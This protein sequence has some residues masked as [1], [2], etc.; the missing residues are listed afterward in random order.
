[1]TKPTTTKPTTVGRREFLASAALVGV[2]LAVSP[3]AGAQTSS[4]HADQSRQ[5]KPG[6]TRMKNRNLGQLQVSELGAGA[7]SIS[8]NYGP[9]ADR[10]QGIATL[11]AA[12]ENGVTFFDTAEVY[13]PYTNEDLVGEALA[14]FR[15]QVVIASKFGFDLE[16]GGL[17]SRPEHI[18]KVVEGSLKRLRTDRIDLYYQH[19]VDPA[20]P[21]EEVAG[22]I[23]ELIAQG[24]V[25]HFGLSEAS[26]ANIRRAHA[27]QPVTAVQSEYAFWFRG[28]EGNGVLKACE[29][30]GIGFVPWSPIGQG[31]LTGKLDASIQFDPKNDFRANFPRLTKENR[32]K[33]LPVV[34]LLE[35]VAKHNNTTPSALALAWLLAQKPFIVPIPGTRRQ[36]H[37]LENL[38]A[39][40]ISL[41]S[42]DL[43]ELESEYA[44]L[45]VHG[46]RM[47]EANMRAIDG[48]PVSTI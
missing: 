42:A 40:D 41:S 5:A 23:K 35:R 12:H 15:D 28:P 39:I 7:M 6:N 43:Q 34:Q 46:L 30:L 20:V 44:L 31:Y 24:K 27:V 29:E 47:D 3:F 4:S 2:G 18:R 13:G 10:K 37:L 11:R 45:T 33:N 36:D 26:A 1:M 14:P 25:L 22:T 32:V 48:W 21:I 19:R 9:P 16:K 17:N 38:G 8:V